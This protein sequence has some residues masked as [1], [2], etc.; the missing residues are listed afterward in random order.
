MDGIEQKPIQ[1]HYAHLKLLLYQTPVGTLFIANRASTSP[2]ATSLRERLID[3]FIESLPEAGDSLF[4]TNSYPLGVTQ[5]QKISPHFFSWSALFTHV[6][7][8][9]DIL[10]VQFV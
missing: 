3:I 7:L 4:C 10:M 5:P 8:H 9:Y 1:G 2:V 6:T